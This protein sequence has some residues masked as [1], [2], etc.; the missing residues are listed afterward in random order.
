MQALLP[1]YN[2][3]AL[4]FS[5]GKDV[6]LYT[7]QGEAYLDFGS[8]VAVNA[9]GHAHPKL[10]NALKQQ[11]E[12][13]WHVSNLYQ[14]PEAEALA[15]T[16]TERSFADTVFFCNSGTEATEAAIKM[17]RKY[18]DAVGNPDK[19]RIIVFEHSF[20]G[21]TLAAASASSRK[22]MNGFE[23][24][25]EGFDVA[26]FGDLEATKDLIGPTTGAVMIEPIQ[27][28]G[29]IYVASQ[30]FIQGLRQLCDKH[31]LL[32]VFDEIQCGMGR[33]GK[34]FAHEHLG[35]T[36]D[37]AMSAKGIGN[38]FPL[39]ACL[40]TKEAAQGMTATTHGSTYGGNPLATSVGIQVLGMLD[41]EL[42]DHVNRISR[43]L[44][45][46]LHEL[47]HSFPSC[48][49]EIRGKGLMLGIK[50][51][52]NINLPDIIALI[53]NEHLLVIPAGDN[54]I[55]LLPPLIITEEHCNE[56]ISKL[57]CAFQRIAL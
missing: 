2:R 26:P 21:R 12:R 28:E 15:H 9:F 10:V 35:V 30:E 31:G 5:Y 43:Y 8:G 48:I 37:I 33:T 17:V 47:R 42:F 44:V 51:N 23:P 20:H 39:G 38:G 25:V 19:F 53:R 16:I 14:I 46:K 11:A 54:V 41:Q 55:R 22:Y 7:S 45:T 36:P 40:A 1:I 13:L 3:T 18:H 52:D 49:T 24:L 6:Y 56:A 4:S 27:G 29:G 34:L 57:T 50:L 32:L